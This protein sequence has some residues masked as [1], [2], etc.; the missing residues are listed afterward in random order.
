MAL[1][2]Y[3]WNDE[4]NFGDRLSAEVVSYVSGREVSWAGPKKCDLFA[5]GSLAHVMRRSHKAPRPD[6]TRPHVWGTGMLMLPADTS[7]TAHLDFAA[8]RGPLTRMLLNLP[9]DLPLGD[10]GLLAAE[11]LGR[12]PKRH[13]RIGIVLHFTRKLPAEVQA[14]IGS[15][16]RF[17]LIDVQDE[18]HMRVVERIGACR[19]VISSSLHGLVVADSFGVPNTWLDPE[20]IHDAMTG[21]KFYDYGLGVG[22]AMEK[23]LPAAEIVAFADSLPKTRRALPYRD[24][25]AAAKEALLASFPESLRADVA[26]EGAVA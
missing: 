9:D 8:V 21:L 6:G 1:R 5:L 14:A 25:I 24:G 20:G 16:D 18:D 3:Y 13:D 17:E 23:P 10:P 22:R 2:L 12:K 19:H 4:V 7:Y 11:A 15:D 26:Q